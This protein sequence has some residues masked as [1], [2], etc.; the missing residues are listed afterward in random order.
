MILKGSEGQSLHKKSGPYMK[1]AAWG[2]GRGCIITTL[3]RFGY[4]HTKGL[5]EYGL[6][7][8]KY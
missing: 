8:D 5:E 7:V 3:Q 1:W 4:M 2:S 6:G